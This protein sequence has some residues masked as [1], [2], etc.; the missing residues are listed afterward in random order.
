MPKEPEDESWVLAE[1]GKSAVHLAAVLDH[2]YN[3]PGVCRRKCCGATTFPQRLAFFDP[4]PKTAPVSAHGYGIAFSDR[5]ENRSW[6]L[7]SK[8]QETLM[9]VF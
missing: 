4:R 8:T 6:Q 7:P 5:S 2:T 1:S 3:R 9:A